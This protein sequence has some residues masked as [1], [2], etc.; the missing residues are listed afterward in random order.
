M[1]QGRD[2]LPYSHS[3]NGTYAIVCVLFPKRE[4]KE[5]S[6]FETVVF[7][8]VALSCITV[9]LSATISVILR[10]RSEEESGRALLKK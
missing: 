4:I 9:R 2:A 3:G 5:K 6:L 7:W 10:E 1:G 8:A